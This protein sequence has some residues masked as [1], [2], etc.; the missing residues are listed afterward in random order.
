MVFETVE[1]MTGF[2][3][4]KSGTVAFSR[5]LKTLFVVLTLLSCEAGW[6]SAGATNEPPDLQTVGSYGSWMLYCR[7]S[8]SDISDCA[9]AQ[10]AQSQSD[11][12]TKFAL[13]ISIRDGT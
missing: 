7:Q 5:L 3:Q 10:A 4:T 11:D 2:F 6:V 13:S 9:I 1:A 8:P 12:N